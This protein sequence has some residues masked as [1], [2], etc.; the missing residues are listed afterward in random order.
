MMASS[1]GSIGFQAG[2][3]STDFVVLVMNDKG[4]RTMPNGKLKLV[5]TQV[6]LPAQ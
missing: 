1:G 4:A 6:L 2:G 3:Q 5:A